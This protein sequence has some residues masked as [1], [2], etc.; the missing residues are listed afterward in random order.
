MSMPI[1]AGEATLPVILG[2]IRETLVEC[3]AI[4]AVLI[5]E[6]C[7][8]GPEGFQATEQVMRKAWRA[9]H[10]TTAAEWFDQMLPFE[11]QFHAL[12]R[13]QTLAG[14]ERYRP[15]RSTDI[16]DDQEGLVRV[17]FTLDMGKLVNMDIAG[18]GY[19]RYAQ[20]GRT[21][22]VALKV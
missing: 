16:L 12:R 3:R 21:E 9:R 7:S 15:I 1:D 18:D 20:V 19:M 8:N 4:Q 22:C 14:L 5:S 10:L 17:K 13:H 11:A 2:A 6:F